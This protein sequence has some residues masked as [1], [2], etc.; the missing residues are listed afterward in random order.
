MQYRD[1][2]AQERRALQDPQH[3]QYWQS[4]VQRMQRAAL[5]RLEEAAGQE[6]SA[7]SERSEAL[8]FSLRPELALGLVEFAHRSGV[9]MKSVFFAAHLNALRAFMGGRE[10]Q[11]GLSLHARPEGAD[12]EKMLGL[13]VNIVPVCF[14]R[15]GGSWQALVQQAHR[16][17][18]AALQHR[19]Y[20]AVEIYRRYGGRQLLD[21]VFNY[22]SFHVYDRLDARLRIKPAA[23]GGEANFPL[24]VNVHFDAES[25]GGGIGLVYKAQRFQ[26]QQMQKLL[27]L[28]VS[29]LREMVEHPLQP[30]Q[31]HVL[32]PPQDHQLLQRWNGTRR[33]YPRESLVHEMFEQQVQNSPRALAL[34]HGDQQLTYEEL[35]WRA[36]RLAH[37]LVRL[38]AGPEVV[39]GLCL[40][41]SISMVVGILGILKAGGAYLPLDPSYPAERLSWM[42]DDAQARVLL[43]RSQVEEVLLA[44]GRQVVRLDVDEGY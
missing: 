14:E 42:L 13:F 25:K 37:H 19:M 33:K 35:D 38:G 8:N 9:S 11:T 43:T 29:S 41:R 27:E 31:E 5:W 3:E 24:L 22:V 44:R 10:V 32:L 4:I 20:P 1:F 7:E 12:T 23:G 15:Q 17:E 40:P 6:S 39:V 30:Y 21:A 16:L 2:I 28:Y 34:I 18:Q 36:N 26:R